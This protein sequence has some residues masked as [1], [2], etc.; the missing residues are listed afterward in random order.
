MSAPAPTTD[1]EICN[2][3]LAR[4]GQTVEI[5]DIDAPDGKTAILCARHYPMTRRRLLRGPRVY[6]FAKKLASLT[7]SGTVTPAHGFASAFALPN[8]YLRLL[9]LGDY[10]I[11]DDTPANLYDIVDGH[12]YTDEED[13]TDTLNIYYIFD[14]TLVAK[15]DAIFVNLMRLELAKDLAYAFTLKASL[16]KQLDDE[17]RDVRLEAGAVAGQEKPPR[18]ISR[19]KWLT[20]RRAGGGRDTTRHSI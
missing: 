4:I 6:N 5:T 20:N 13:D 8:D 14:Q 7:V 18:R 11:N 9:A 15:W 16:V 2:L 3:A 19:S 10:T 17:L 12:I 1:V